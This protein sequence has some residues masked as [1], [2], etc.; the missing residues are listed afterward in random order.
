[1]RV[2]G[3]AGRGS[4]FQRLDFTKNVKERKENKNDRDT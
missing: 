4:T 2:G 1:M 3:R